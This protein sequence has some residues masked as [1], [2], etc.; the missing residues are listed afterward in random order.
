MF[1]NYR[2][3]KNNTQEISVHAGRIQ[4]GGGG[5]A[6]GLEPLENTSYIGF[7]RE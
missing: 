1:Q 2:T 6:G 7:D 3:I 4:R 5:G